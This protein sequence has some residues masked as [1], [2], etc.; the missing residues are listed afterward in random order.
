MTGEPDVQPLSKRHRSVFFYALFGL[1]ILTLPLFILYA[2][3][4]RF[5]FDGSTTF[6]STGGIYIAADRTGAEIYIDNELVRETRTFR[7]AFYA[8]SIEPGTHRVHVQKPNHHTWVK[9]LPVYPHLV[10]E[11]QAFNM[12]LVPQVRVIS[13]WRTRTGETVLSATSSLS[14]STTND[15]V[16]AT[17]TATSTLLLDTEYVS[18][19]ALF[20]TSTATSSASLYERVSSVL[21][22]GSAGTSTA[23]S[24]IAEAT[25]TKEF[26][27]VRLYEEAGV[28]YAR[29]VGSR[30]DM[31][32]Y[33][34]AEDY[35]LLGTSTV[36]LLSPPI[37]QSASVVDAETEDLLLHPVQQVE[38]DTACDPTIMINTAGQIA[39]TFDFYPNSTDFVLVALEDGIY[40]IEI[41][42]RGWQ[43]KQPL[44]MGENLDVRVEGGN[45]YVSDGTL[46]YA[47]QLET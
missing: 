21:S 47:V 5:S 26:Q 17:S 40:V 43:N 3:G 11:A 10:T 1:F 16:I 46:L 7:R 38:D 35:E 36:P 45:V 33:Y 8:Q 30:A 39:R 13:P 25:T 19:T 20:A 29:F 18:L 32:Y 34:C 27:G 24:T 15:F 12:P 42:D 14:A 28:V 37:A 2:I 41:D 4:Y 31:P 22:T 6:F 23:T 44:V 9:E